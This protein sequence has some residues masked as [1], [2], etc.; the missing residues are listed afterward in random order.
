M[1]ELKKFN[2]NFSPNKETPYFQ[3]TNDKRIRFILDELS[4]QT[5]KY[6]FK[7]IYKDKY[8]N[9]IFISDYILK[10]KKQY[11]NYK[12][13]IGNIIPLKNWEEIIEP[14]EKDDD[15]TKILF[16]KVKRLNFID[17]YNYSLH[18]KKGIPELY[19]VFYSDEFLVYLN[20]DVIDII[21]NDKENI[22]KLKKEFKES[23]NK[24]HE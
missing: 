9:T 13:K 1:V 17:L 10:N 15:E 12:K 3:T 16:A 20:S 23:Y 19:I 11:I 2:I 21:S 7:K 6:I 14:Y 18:L 8:I 4:L 24:L 22:N 5:T